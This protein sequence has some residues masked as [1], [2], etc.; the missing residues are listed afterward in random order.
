M[1]VGESPI[2]AAVNG[3]IEV[4]PAVFT[5]V[6]TTIVIFLIFFFLQGALGD[7]AKDLAFVV[8]ATLIFSLIEGHVHS[9][10]PYSTFK[11]AAQG[12]WQE[13]WDPAK[14]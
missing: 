10:R 11:S 9:A 1:S 12:R 3:T 13:G 7:R 2:K 6:S 5:G 8:A 4:L 14:S